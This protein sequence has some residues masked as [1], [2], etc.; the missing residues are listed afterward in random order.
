SACTSTLIRFSTRCR[1]RCLAAGGGTSTRRAARSRCRCS[2]AEHRRELVIT[3][4]PDHS[5][6]R[7]GIRY[8]LGDRDELVN[9]ERASLREAIHPQG[10]KPLARMALGV[11][12][13]LGT[14]ERLI[15]DHAD[16]TDR[17]STIWNSDARP[18]SESLAPAVGSLRVE[19]SFA[20]HKIITTLDRLPGASTPHGVIR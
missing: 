12:I 11:R 6:W 1:S 10:L 5:V 16:K 20:V 2:F 4:Y 8:T 7:T 17:S 3:D 14:D 15:T 13:E 9:C 18:N 19:R